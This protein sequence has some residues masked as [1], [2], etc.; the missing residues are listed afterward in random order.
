[1]TVKQDID[2]TTG[3]HTYTYALSNDIKVGKDGKDGI[4]GKIGVNG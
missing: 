1:M 3:E 4:D 2:A